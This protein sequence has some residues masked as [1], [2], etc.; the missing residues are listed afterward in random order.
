MPTETFTV[1]LTN[2]KTNTFS[3][4]Q[5]N[6]LIFTKTFTPTYINEI[7]IVTPE[8]ELE[9]PIIKKDSLRKT[10]EITLPK[11]LKASLNENTN[12]AKAKVTY[13]IHIRKLKRLGEKDNSYKLGKKFLSYQRKNVLKYK[14]LDKGIY[15]IRYQ[16]IITKGHKV[17]TTKWSKRALVEI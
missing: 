4:T 12:V 16:V 7:E 15:S 17:K 10:L 5:T 3:Y 13:L 14:N 1:T 2:T 6:T 8:T 11:I 9:G